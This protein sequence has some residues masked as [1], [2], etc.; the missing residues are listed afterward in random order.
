VTVHRPTRRLLPPATLIALALGILLLAASCSREGPSPFA[1][2]YPSAATLEQQTHEKVNE[3]RVSKGLADLAWSDVIAGQARQHSQ[4]M[5]S[6]AVSLGHDGFDDRL[7]AIARS[8]QWSS[9]AENVAMKQNTANPA[10]AALE[11]WLDSSGHRANIEG[12]FSVT[13]VGVSKTGDGSVYFTQ[14]FI[15]SR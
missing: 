3:H 10:A 6:G 5:A 4:D 12:N 2:S 14:V 7:A 8:L 13:G 1:A 11:G 9:A 15:K